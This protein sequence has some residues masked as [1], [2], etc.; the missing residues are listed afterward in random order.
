MIYRDLSKLIVIYRRLYHHLVMGIFFLKD[1]SFTMQMMTDLSYVN[2]YK[3][4]WQ[5]KA[6]ALGRAKLESMRSLGAFESIG[7]SNRIEGN[8][9]S[10]GEVEKLLSGLSTKSF[11][12]RDEEEVAGYSDALNIIQRNYNDIPLTENYIK[13]LHSILL[14]YTTKDERHRG[15][16]KALANSVA[17]FDKE[18]HEV[19]IVFRTAEPYETPTLMQELVKETNELLLDKTFD[20]VISIGLFIVHFLAIH[21]FQDGN[22]RMSRI[23][24]MLLLLKAGYEYV[25]YY[26]LEKIIE[27]SKSTYYQALS[28]T[29]LSFSSGKADY[30]PWLGYF[31]GILKS[32]ADNLEKKISAYTSST[33]LNMKEESVVALLKANGGLS[34]SEICRNLPDITPNTIKGILRRLA[35]RG[36]IEK[37]GANKGTWYSAKLK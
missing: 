30:S 32:Q 13:Q 27:E 26:S 2:A 11:R 22:G 19:G 5:S 7:S 1:L 21:P 23:L 8:T 31:L 3:M 14:K 25:P 28:R 15:E 29:Q 16:Y 33:S 10:D 12:S 20:P 6:E 36:I 37:H 24:T 18:E 4:Q 9:L 17:A 34:V 35:D